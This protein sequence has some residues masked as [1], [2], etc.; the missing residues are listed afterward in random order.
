MVIST[1]SGP[2][3][4]TLVLEPGLAALA[5]Q[6][7]AFEV[8]DFFVH[9]RI[10]LKRCT[11]GIKSSGKRRGYGYLFPPTSKER[12]P[13]VTQNLGDFKFPGRGQKNTLGRRAAGTTLN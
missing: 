10:L 4:R 1:C 12:H 7:H 3:P 8:N 2:K 11:E 9:F 13:E 6:H 5:L